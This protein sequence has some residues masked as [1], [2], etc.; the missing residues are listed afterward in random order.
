MNEEGFDMNTFGND[1]FFKALKESP[2][3]E[4]RPSRDHTREDILASVPKVD[5]EFD[6]KK[7]PIG[8][9]RFLAFEYLFD[10]QSAGLFSIGFAEAIFTSVQS[11]TDLLDKRL[12]LWDNIILT[13]G[14]SVVKG[15]Y[16]GSINVLIVG[17]GFRER[18]EHE[19]SVFLAASETSSEFQ[20]KEMKYLKIPEYFSNFRDKPEDLVYLGGTIVAK[21]N[22]SQR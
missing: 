10:P 17:K 4:I 9:S 7:V 18:L 20:A 22:I 3:C 14:S 19:L 8:K 21:D 13:G 11:S 16:T 1:L 5:F 12:A 15:T 2:I 6:G